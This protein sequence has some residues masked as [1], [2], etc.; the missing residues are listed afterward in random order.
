MSPSTAECLEHAA[1]ASG[2]WRAP[3]MKLTG[4]SFLECAGIEEAG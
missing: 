3:K 4:N 2:T 1:N